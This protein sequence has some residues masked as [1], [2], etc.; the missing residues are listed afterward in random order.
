MGFHTF[1]SSGAPNHKVCPNPST[2]TC[3]RQVISAPD[4]C[5]LQLQFPCPCQLHFSVG[6]DKAREMATDEVMQQ[7]VHTLRSAPLPPRDPTRASATE[8]PLPGA[9][10]GC[11]LP[12]AVSEAAISDSACKHSHVTPAISKVL[13]REKLMHLHL[14][15]QLSCPTWSIMWI[16]AMQWA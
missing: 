8:G 7:G 1:V 15:S 4:E 9:R 16:T 12:H 6:H 11:H 13:G 5:T 14:N 10:A 3:K 2:R